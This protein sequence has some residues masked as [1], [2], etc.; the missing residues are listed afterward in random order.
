[1]TAARRAELPP[2]GGQHRLPLGVV[3]VC[4][5]APEVQGAVPSLETPVLSK[6]VARWGGDCG[7]WTGALRKALDTVRRT[8]SE[9]DKLLVRTRPWR[10]A[11]ARARGQRR[12]GSGGR[13][14]RRS[15]PD[16]DRGAR[17]AR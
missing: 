9:G 11:I 14:G 3:L 4:D 2:R 7:D 1:M 17:F 16:A 15:A 8:S 12:E 13:A 10:A 6:D 5:F